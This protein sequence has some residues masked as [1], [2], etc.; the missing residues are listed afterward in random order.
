[1][2]TSIVY[3]TIKCIVRHDED[4]DPE[5]LMCE[6]D[7]RVDLEPEGQLPHII[8][9]EMMEAEN[10]GECDPDEYFLLD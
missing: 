7:Y 9:T 2:K 3:L 10:R 5:E 8:A 1:M 6:A 4:D